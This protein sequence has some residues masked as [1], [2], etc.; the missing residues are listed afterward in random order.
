[1]RSWPAGRVAALR[2]MVSRL[3][4]TL[5][6]TLA[7]QVHQSAARILNTKIPFILDLTITAGFKQ[8]KVDFTVPPGLGGTSRGASKH[9]DRQLLFYEIQ[10]SSTNTFSDPVILQT[11]QTSTLVS[12][13]TVGQVRFFRARVINTKNEASP[14]SATIRSRAARGRIS[15]N[16]MEVGDKST[17]LVAGTGQ[18]QTVFSEEYEAAESAISAM[19]HI[20]VGAVQEDVG[21]YAGGPA[22]VQFRWLIDIN[23][24]AEFREIEGGGRCV[25]SAVPGSTVTK[26]GKAPM[27]FGSFMTPFLNAP[28]TGVVGIRLQ[29]A[30][31]PG[32]EWSPGGAVDTS[33]DLSTDSGNY[34]SS[35]SLTHW[36][37][38]GSNS[39]DI[40]K[41]YVG[42]IDI[43]Q[44]A[45]NIG[46]EDIFTTPPTD[47]PYIDFDGISEFLANTSANTYG[48]GA[49][50]SVS[51]WCRVDG[52]LGL[53]TVI[54]DFNVGTT[55][56]NRWLIFKPATDL[57][58][59]R[60]ANAAGTANETASGTTVVT[61]DL[62]KT[63][64][65][66]A[67]TKTGTASQTIYINGVATTDAVGGVV[68]SDASRRA[69]FAAN[70]TN[71][72]ANR[73]DGA[74]HSVATWSTV[75]TADE[76][77][78]IFNA[79][80]GATITVQESDP[81][82]FIRNNKVLEVIQD[83]NSNA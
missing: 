31:R 64:F 29:A 34:A 43:D 27:A 35:S 62:G 49:S 40:G 74:L 32:T 54:A 24:T 50:G 22:H 28:G 10:H 48:L 76:V 83:F 55:Q 77:T 51:L 41:D 79:G 72:T 61:G 3:E 18:W 58:S 1:M 66:I 52:G 39:S 6:D 12:G 37:R 25:M 67:V 59:F 44:N 46:A 15:V 4:T 57:L 42:S 16:A 21:F 80:H 53:T 23:N 8:F 2:L 68:T 81:I 56:S 60:A 30:K 20:A 36:W 26:R 47:G 70:T 9:P 11:P 13:V 73:F 82:I 69:A 14:W 75:L 17:R 45:Q 19:T 5:N 38:L 65:H 7:A 78:E 63:W 71:L 33:L